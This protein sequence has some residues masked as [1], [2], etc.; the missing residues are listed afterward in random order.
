MPIKLTEA[1]RILKD[2]YLYLVNENLSNK[3]SSRIVK[4]RVVCCKCKKGNTTL[5][6]LSDGQYICNNCY[7]EENNNE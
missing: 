6:K 4:G 2:V 7:R 5:R 3:K 1:D